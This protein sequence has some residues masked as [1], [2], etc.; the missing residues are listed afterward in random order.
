M[1]G[2]S[3]SL[4]DFHTDA[5]SG[6]SVF[7]VVLWVPLTRAYKSNSMFIFSRSKTYEI[8]SKLKASEKKGMKNLY[9]EYKEYATFLKLNLGECLIFSPT[10]FHGNVINNTDITRVSINCRFKNIFSHEAQSGERRLGS[11]YRVL[12][13]SPVT[14]LGLAYK[15]EIINF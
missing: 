13:I 2:D 8:L 5:L 11:F 6:Q 14:E 12:N 4:L 1:P 3:S 7:E 15:D 9:N 10:L